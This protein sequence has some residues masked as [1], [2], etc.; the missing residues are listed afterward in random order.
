MYLSNPQSGLIAVTKNNKILFFDGDAT[1]SGLNMYDIATN[2]WSIV[3]LPA[4][5]DGASVISVSNTIYVAGGF[6]NGIYN[7]FNDKVW[8][9]EL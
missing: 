5:I 4:P 2:T 3:M 6:V 1:Q 7:V 8:T 9:L